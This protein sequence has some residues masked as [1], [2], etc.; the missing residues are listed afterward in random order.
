MDKEERLRRPRQQDTM[1]NKK[2][3]GNGGR[4]S[5]QIGLTKRI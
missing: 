1:Y 4:K 2:V 3:K 5:G